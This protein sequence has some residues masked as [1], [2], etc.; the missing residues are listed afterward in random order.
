VRWILAGKN[1]AA[2]QALEHLLAQGDEVL[3][4]GGA[5][6]DGRNGWQRSLRGAAERQGVPF[7]QPER[8]NAPESIAVL[9]DY[10]ADALISIQYE[11]ILRK[12]LFEAIGCPCL[13]LHFALLPRHRGVA[14]IAWAI[15]SGDREAGVTLHHMVPE[16]DAGDVIAQR[17]VAIE[18][19]HT[20]RDVY[21]RVSDAAVALF[22]ES[23]PFAPQLL[24]QRGI[25]CQREAVYH[26]SGDFDFSRRQV[27]WSQPALPL[28]RWLRTM[29]FPP[30]QL[31]ETRLAGQPL[32]IERIAGAIGPA[33]AEPPGSIVAVGE[34]GIDVAAAGGSI[35]ITRLAATE[36]GLPRITRGDRFEA[37]PEE[38]P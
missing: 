1:D 21:E 9:A 27:D 35:R 3:A 5:G 22:R 29:I 24:A 20:A 6:D 36:S 34:A 11:Q 23:Y 37:I 38:T 10:G 18:P 31:P 7:V 33:R 4:V 32:R 16:I 25:Q 12:R 15:L 30:L 26:K 17:A 8:V 13:N 14:P 2:C 19:D 28:H